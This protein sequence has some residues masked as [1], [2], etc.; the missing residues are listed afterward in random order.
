[1]K[2]R[3]Y[4]NRDAAQEEKAQVA[5]MVECLASTDIQK[6]FALFG[7]AAE[8][9]GVRQIVEL[10]VEFKASLNSWPA[11]RPRPQRLGSSVMSHQWPTSLLK[12]MGPTLAAISIG[13]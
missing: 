3:R 13:R 5:C 12:S 4:L 9:I 7:C 8:L 10:A 11:I 6:K 1:M 2:P